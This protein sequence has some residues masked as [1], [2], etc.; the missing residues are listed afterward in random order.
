MTRHP[1]KF[2]FPFSLSAV[3]IQGSGTI[4][5]IEYDYNIKLKSNKEK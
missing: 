4:I 3:N 1:V 5:T 2:N